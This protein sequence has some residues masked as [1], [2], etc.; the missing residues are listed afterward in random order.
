MREDYYFRLIK[1][2]GKYRRG[3]WFNCYK[4]FVY[5]IAD[6]ENQF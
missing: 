3:Q 5:G 1:D 4:G 6:G 2:A